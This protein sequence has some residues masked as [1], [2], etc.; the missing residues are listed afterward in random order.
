MF[1]VF[2]PGG[3][4][5]SNSENNVTLTS[6]LTNGTT[7]IT[8]GITYQWAKYSSGKYTNIS[9]ATSASL[10]VTPDM[11]DS[12]ASFRCTA[13]YGSKDYIAYWVVRDVQ[14]PAQFYQYCTLGNE[15]TN[16][17]LGQPGAIYILGFVK[18]QEIDPIKT[19]TFSTTAPSNPSAGDY[20]YK[21][22]KTQKTV[23]LMKYSGSAWAEAPESDQPTGTYN[24]YRRNSD[25][26]L[27]DTATA[28]KTGKVIYVDTT[29]VDK[30]LVID[31]EVTI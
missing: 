7:I 10:E 15:W 12:M 28:W 1:Q 5:I 6:Q 22:D 26:T 17:E 19:T 13:T 3:D 30:K 11:V 25:G 20:Y 21:L 29:M 18:N 31:Y 2:A 8:S 16:G 27:L 9:G 23:T 4:I 24:Y 14:D